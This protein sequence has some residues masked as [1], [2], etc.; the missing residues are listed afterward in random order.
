MTAELESYDPQVPADLTALSRDELVEC[1]RKVASFSEQV[2]SVSR[3]VLGDLACA[4]ET[5]Y[6]ES[7]L[8]K[9]AEEVGVQ[10]STLRDYAQVSRA[11]PASCRLATTSWTVYRTLAA[12]GD[13]L[14]LVAGDRLT[15]DQAR[16]IVHERGRKKHA[17]W[18][19]QQAKERKKNA[20][21][22]KVKAPKKVIAGTVEPGT[23]ATQA[24]APEPAAPAVT[25]T[26]TAVPEDAYARLEEKF[27]AA[28]EGKDAEIAR[29]SARVREQDEKLAAGGI[30]A[31]EAAL[32]KLHH[33]CTAHQRS[34]GFIAQ[35]PNCGQGR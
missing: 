22:P 34:A 3:W 5:S 15:V 12:Q 33:P 1:G 27:A 2:T 23:T 32:A 26:A 28:L 24:T 11:F 18:K 35:C 13:R 4:V 14:E 30:I 19:R 8:G 31:L 9:Y 20:A 16:D 10:W 17:R 7:E 29:L 21:Q 25:A 6:G